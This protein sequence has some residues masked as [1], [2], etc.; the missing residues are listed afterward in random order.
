MK[1]SNSG[2][3]QGKGSRLHPISL[4][5]FIAKAIKDLLYP[6]LVFLIS[7]IVRKEVNL[8]WIG[9][10]SV[11]FLLLLISISYL[12][13][14]RF[15][16][17]LENNALHVEQG[18]FVRK[19]T[20]ITR[21]RV[22]SV[23]TTAGVVHRVLGLVKV[24]VETAGGKK[25]EVALNAITGGEAEKIR[26]A[27]LLGSTPASNSAAAEPSSAAVN[28]HDLSGEDGIAA[29]VAEERAAVPIETIPAG[30]PEP[31]DTRVL[32][33]KDLLLFSA[34]SGRVGVIIALFGAAYSQLDDVLDRF[35][36]F[37]GIIS[38]W[39][40]THALNIG[41]IALFAFAGLLVAW[42]LAIL[43]TFVKEY[44][45]TLTRNGDKL[46]ITRG[47]LEK[48]QITVPL[49]SIQAIH[50]TQNLLRRPFGW[51]SVHV[52]ATGYDEKNGTSALMFPLLRKTELAS[53]LQRFA[54]QYEMPDQWQRL[55]K[56]SL[57]SFLT[58][59]LLLSIAV[60][61]PAIIW[62]PGSYGWLAVLLPGLVG[63]SAWLNYK[64]TAWHAWDGRLFI[65][66][67]GFTKHQAL[68]HRRRV[69]WNRMSE[70]PFQLRKNLAT[71]SVALASGR[72]RAMFSIRHMSAV[73][74]RELK[75]WFAGHKKPS[76]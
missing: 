74:A 54:P 62:I 16:Y 40:S 52:V 38:S 42:L 47:L 24:S 5:F 45:F 75:G 11:L 58:V 33:A 13:W 65:Q 4:V 19:K 18:V 12:T 67:G 53:F 27:L 64:Q 72:N 68:I 17:Y 22:Q 32:S 23:D 63:V 56:R 9:G 59:P 35:I 20:W 39:F 51:F 15:T 31:H 69:Q 60:I 48:K 66:Y 43:I 71:I 26:T 1:R 7:T 55:E 8:L 41:L 50:L 44:G 70:T 57:A 49:Q 10:G 2:E 6:L 36:D 46:V 25:P 21:D 37:K 30:A 3:P 73:S 28:G 61:I 76:H 29:P 34:T 14:Y